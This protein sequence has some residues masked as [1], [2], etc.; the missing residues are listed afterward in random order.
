MSEL[1]NSRDFSGLE[2]DGLD[3]SAIFGDGNDGKAPDDPFA[4]PPDADKSAPEAAKQSEPQKKDVPEPDLFAAFAQDAEEPSPVKKQNTPQQTSLSLFDKPPVFSYGGAKEKIED[5]SQT[6]EELRIAKADDFPELAEG[7]SVSWRVKYGDISKPVTDPKATTIASMKEEIEKSKAFLD[8]LKKSKEKSPD[9]LVIPSVFAKS[10][11]I[12]AYKGV[13]PSL[14]E[15]RAYDR[16]LKAVC[17]VRLCD[18]PCGKRFLSH[19]A[20][21]G[22]PQRP[23]AGSARPTQ[24]SSGRMTAKNNTRSAKK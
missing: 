9:C 4:E 14:E 24:R 19:C 18:A 20:Y 2:N 6:F 5:A 16:C 17:R 7:K 12:A 3:F 13:F 23:C 15:A 21:C 8:S 10:K 1:E 22:G 11:G